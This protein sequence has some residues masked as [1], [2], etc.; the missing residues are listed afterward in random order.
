MI[1]FKLI[2]ALVALVLLSLALANGDALSQSQ[3]THSFDTCFSS[4]NR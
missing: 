1:K 4:L 3:E 2:L